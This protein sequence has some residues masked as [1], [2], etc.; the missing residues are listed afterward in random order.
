MGVD[1]IGYADGGR[2]DARPTLRFM[3]SPL[4]RSRMRWDREPF[5]IPLTR[6]SDTLSPSGGVGRGE[7]VPR[8]MESRFV[9]LFC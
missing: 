9:K 3:E 8:F 4:S 5:R 1:A 7:G 2:R 6:P